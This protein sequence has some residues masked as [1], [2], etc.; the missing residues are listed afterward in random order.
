VP[1]SILYS[2]EIDTL[3]GSRIFFNGPVT[4]RE[5]GKAFV[6]GR[7]NITFFAASLNIKVL[8][9]FFLYHN[10]KQTFFSGNFY[11]NK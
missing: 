9:L 11:R 10:A 1:Y 5:G 2:Q 7:K 3:K 4:K 8:K 6:A